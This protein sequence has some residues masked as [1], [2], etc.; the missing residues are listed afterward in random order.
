[1]L[2]RVNDKHMHNTSDGSDHDIEV[3]PWGGPR[4]ISIDAPAYDAVQPRKPICIL[5]GKGRFGIGW[6]RVENASVS[7]R[8]NR[9]TF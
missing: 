4:M 5:R 3:D 9:A 2:V 7:H 1:M 6:Y 8:C